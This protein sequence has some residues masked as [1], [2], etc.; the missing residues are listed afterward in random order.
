ME[1]QYDF[2]ARLECVHKAGR[3]NPAGKPGPN[4]VVIGADW[5]I[6][7]DRGAS[8]FLEAAA[9]DLQDYFNTSLGIT[10]SFVRSPL[11]GRKL[12]LSKSIILAVKRELPTWAGKSSTPRGYRIVCR[13]DTVILC[14]N[15]ERG[16]AQAGYY[17]EDLLNLSEAPFLEPC[18]TERE[19]V[20]SPRMT[21]SG[22]G[23]DDFPDAYLNAIAHTGMDSVLLFVKD[24]DTTRGGRT[25]INDLIKRAAAFGLDVYFYSMMRNTRH[26]DDPGAEEFYDGTIG[27]LLKNHPGARGIVFVGE[28]CEFPSRD[29]ETNGMLFGD[30]PKTGRPS[31]KP[32]PGWWPCRDFPQWVALIKK[33]MRK[34]NPA[35]EVVFWTYNFGWAPEKKRLGL[36][37][38]LPADI[39][40]LVTFE[41]FEQIKH[42]GVTHVTVDYTISFPGPGSVFRA[43]AATAHKRGDLRLYTMSNTGGMTWDVSPIPYLPVPFQWMKRYAALH[44]A[45][46]VWGLSGLMESHHYGFWPSFVSELAKWSFWT[47][48]VSLETMAEQIAVRDFGAKAAP[49][50]V[51]AWKAWSKAMQFYPPTNEDQ[52][53]PFRTGPSYPFTFKPNLSKQ[54][55][56][57][58]YRLPG[59]SEEPGG[60]DIILTDYQPYEDPRQS[61]GASRMPVE[62]RDLSRMARLWHD[63]LVHLEAAFACVPAGK[64]ETLDRMHGLGRFI[65]CSIRT[66]INTKQWWRLNQRL[67]LE[68]NPQKA[69]VILDK[70]ETLAKDEIENAR[71]TIPVVEADSRLG[72]EPT[73]GYV[74]DR[75]HLEWKIRQVQDVLEDE[76]PKY[77]K[78]LAL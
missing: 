68:G 33:V 38:K 34:H 32:H 31:G 29:P 13:D 28:S 66:T 73:M 18:D 52:Y 5:R 2:R 42:A 44:R 24:P 54:F 74:A 78:T 51:K 37:R 10:L 55:A 25:D 58:E 15:D 27:R 7:I 12:P 46:Q 53:G 67:L 11:I 30:A 3:R 69:G 75:A 62:I 57:K 45:G 4:D 35:A 63:G 77:R 20:F 23:L 65:Y 6:V 61:P 48:A 41:M 76:I 72:W 8:V 47:P 22:F 26:P 70:L 43:E 59:P 17:L 40:L 71:S 36:I 16:A 50:V 9:H 1:Q 64:K 21:H 56:R 49:L 19:P 60:G 14:G 39:S